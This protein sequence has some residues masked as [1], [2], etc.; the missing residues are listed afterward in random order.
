M[1]RENFHKNGIYHIYNRGV[2]KAEIFTENND[3]LRFLSQL[4]TFNDLG[5]LSETN[6]QLSL[7]KAKKPLVEI[8]MFNLLPN[9]F[10]LLVKNLMDSG[11]SK[12][13]QRT[14]NGYAKYYNR[15]YKRTG[16]LFEGPY[17]CINIDNDPYLNQV[18]RYIS[19]NHLDLYGIQWKEG[20]QTDQIAKAIQISEQYKWSSTTD[21]LSEPLFPFL[22]RN[23][24]LE[25][26]EN[27]F[28]TIFY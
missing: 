6:R 11:V 18:M 17:K 23:D 20:L 26:T 12:L 16:P 27:N 13:M 2:N 14:Q 9:H 3:H 24:V 25:A 4:A 8:M 5:N 10:H 21:Y 28:K 1:F 19:L 7:S 15:K 22:E